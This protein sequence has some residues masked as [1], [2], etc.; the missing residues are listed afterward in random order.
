V[1]YGGSDSHVHALSV[2]S[3]ALEPLRLLGNPHT[4]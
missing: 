1:M 2:L 3:F 4:A